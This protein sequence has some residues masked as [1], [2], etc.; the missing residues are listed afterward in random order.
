MGLD[1]RTLAPNMAISDVTKLLK[2]N[3]IA[4]HIT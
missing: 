3:R 4:N 2:K 1:P